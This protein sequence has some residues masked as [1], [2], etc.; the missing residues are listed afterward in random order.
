MQL[1]R[2]S[3]A[4]SFLARAESWLLA[5]E[6]ENNLIIGIAQRLLAGAPG[7]DPPFYL[8]SIHAGDTVCGAAFR[9]PPHQLGLTRLAPGAARLQS[10][11]IE[12]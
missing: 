5:A 1:E 8:A 2:H 6:P 9:T 10:I 7:Y 4:A 11:P 3:D 12:V